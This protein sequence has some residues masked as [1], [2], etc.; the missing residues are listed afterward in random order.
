M[1]WIK[2]ILVAMVLALLGGCG[3]TPHTN[4]YVLSSQSS[5]AEIGNNPISLGIGPVE[6]AQYLD[7]LQITFEKDGSLELDDFNRWGEPLYVGITRVVMEEL[8]AQL[9]TVNLVQFP[10]RSDEIPDFRIKI[11][12]L[13]LNRKDRG[14]VLKA[15]WSLGDTR[16][17]DLL[18]QTVEVLH[19]P[20]H[21]HGYS[22]LVEGYSRLL[23]QLSTRMAAVIREKSIR[24]KSK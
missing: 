5:L 12:V 19:E 20:L 17:G 1:R 9:D 7:R 18:H 14:A 8:A 16:S 13:E 2:H 23:Q 6:V 22:A 21:G 15:A 10:W 3:T 11:V 24:E 4:Y